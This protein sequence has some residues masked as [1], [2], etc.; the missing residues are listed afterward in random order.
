[1][2]G[3]Y[4]VIMQITSFVLGSLISFFM[5]WYFYKKADFPSR[6]TSAMSEDV[7]LLLIQNKAGVDFNFQGKIL[8]DEMPKTLTVPHILKY[9]LSN[10]AINLGENLHLLF[11]VEDTDFDFLGAE[12]VEITE[13]ESNVSFPSARQG[14]GYYSCEIKCPIKATPGIHMLTVKLHD[15][16]NNMH[17]H[18]I[19]FEVL[20]KTNVNRKTKPNI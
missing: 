17:S 10:K 9:W 13:M 15:A 11:R 1:M 6:V 5:S 20:P 18:I 8:K 12:N 19:K 7:L 14:H 2:I 4:D 16:K 3:I